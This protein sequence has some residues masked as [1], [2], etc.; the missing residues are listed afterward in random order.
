MI[1]LS[2]IPCE[3]KFNGVNLDETGKLILGGDTSQTGGFVARKAADECI[4]K[5]NLQNSPALMQMFQISMKHRDQYATAAGSIEGGG[6]KGIP[7]PTDGR[8]YS[9]S[10]RFEAHWK[11]Y[12]EKSAELAGIR[13]LDHSGNAGLPGVEPGDKAGGA[14]GA[15][16]TLGVTAYNEMVAWEASASAEN[17]PWEW[18]VEPDMSPSD[19]PGPH[20]QSPGDFLDHSSGGSQS[21]SGSDSSGSSNSGSSSGSSSSSDSDHSNDGHDSSNDNDNNHG[22]FEST[23]DDDFEAIPDDVNTGSDID[24]SDDLDATPVLDDFN[25]KTAMQKCQEEEERELW[26]QIGSEE[27]DPDAEQTEQ[28]KKDRAETLLGMGVC[29]PAYYD[30]QTCQDF[31]NKQWEVPLT[32]EMKQD[33][34]DWHD[35]H[36]S[37]P[38][39]VVRESDCHKAQ[40]ELYK[41]YDINQ[42]GDEMMSV[43]A[44]PGPSISWLPDLSKIL[45]LVNPPLIIEDVPKSSVPAGGGSP[46]ASP[47]IPRLP[48]AF[49]PD[50]SMPPPFKVPKHGSGL[51]T[52]SSD[53]PPKGQFPA[54]KF[55]PTG[56]HAL[57]A[58]IPSLRIPRFHSPPIRHA[59]ATGAGLLGSSGLGHDEL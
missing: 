12:V 26:K 47:D 11:A 9:D 49:V 8:W 38:V 37:C 50:L 39:N 33:L 44:S 54:L 41:R 57:P 20:E 56:T 36:P 22:D 46:P 10:A 7:R 31:K 55:S 28:S 27:I 43:I 29:D 34:K 3:S 30:R 17:T 48:S 18:G 35:S 1:G 40:Q 51:G 24:I 53:Q 16:V 45:V 6:G 42:M 2:D 21:S 4:R 23:T 58:V 32:P 15:F 25:T 52:P 13:K 5:A 59:P 19:W 14:S